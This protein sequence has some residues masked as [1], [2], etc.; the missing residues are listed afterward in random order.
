MSEFWSTRKIREF[1]FPP[2]KT[3]IFW[4]LKRHPRNVIW[5]IIWTKPDHFQVQNVKNFRFFWYVFVVGKKTPQDSLGFFGHMRSNGT[6]GGLIA[7]IVWWGGLE[8]AS[9][10]WPWFPSN[11]SGRFFG[12]KTVSHGGCFGKGGGV[13]TKSHF[14]EFGGRKI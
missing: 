12:H 7:S 9:C 13:D 14:E 2:P 4:N 3:K 1:F 10:W 8:V 5:R 6:I 11:I